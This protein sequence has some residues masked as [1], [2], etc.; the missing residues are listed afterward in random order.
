MTDATR[1]TGILT[2]FDGI[3][4][5]SRLEAR[6]AAFFT[7]IGWKFTYEPFDGNGYIP[8]FLIHGKSPLLVEVKPAHSL[9]GFEEPIEK[10]NKGLRGHWSDDAL[11]VGVD[12]FVAP[13]P[14]DGGW[15]DSF[16]SMGR[17]G[18]AD[19]TC[20]YYQEDCSHNSLSCTASWHF[21]AAVLAKCVG[22]KGA[23]GGVGVFSE[24]M[25]YAHSPCGHYDGGHGEPVDLRP[26][27]A[28]AINAVKWR[29]TDA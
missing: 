14:T 3:E 9:V 11:I 25:S 27:W 15:D 7:E 21:D 28:R 22:I 1:S 24:L 29:G 19:A 2:L 10:M 20:G 16:S 17:F 23:C 5:R 26:A 4:Y 13:W 18:S 8:D 6:W 12:P